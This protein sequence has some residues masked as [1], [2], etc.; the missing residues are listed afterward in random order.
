[1]HRTQ[2]RLSHHSIV[3]IFCM[4]GCL[5]GRSSNLKY[6]NKF[7]RHIRRHYTLFAFVV[8]LFFSSC[9]INLCSVLRR[10]FFSSLFNS[11]FIKNIASGTQFHYIRFWFI[12]IRSSSF[13]SIKMHHFVCIRCGGGGGIGIERWF[14]KY[15]S[16]CW[17]KMLR[18]S[19]KSNLLKLWIMFAELSH[20]I[21]FWDWFCHVTNYMHAVYVCASHE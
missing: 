17:A 5:R 16:V 19:G 13:F 7:I 15:A 1:M 21:S 10:R 3:C 6:I 9:T 18:L 20:S 4:C 14:E 12:F 8:A 2:K 11:W